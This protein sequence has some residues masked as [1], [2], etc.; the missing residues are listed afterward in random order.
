MKYT[1]KLIFSSLFKNDAALEGRKQKWWIALILFLLSIVLA[2]VP[3]TVSILKTQGD[4]FM[5]GAVYSLDHG[6]VRFT[7][8]LEDLNIDLR[9]ALNEEEKVIVNEGSLWQTSF[10]SIK[11]FPYLENEVTT[12]YDFHYFSYTD[13]SSQELLRIYYYQDYSQNV[14]TAFLTSLSNLENSSDTVNPEL[15][16]FIFINRL[17]F[18]VNLYS[19]AGVNDGTLQG[20]TPTKKFWGDYRNVTLDTN[21]KTFGLSDASGHVYPSPTT[22]EQLFDYQTRVWK[23]Y[24]NFFID[25]YKAN[26]Q[27]NLTTNVLIYLALNTTLSFFMMLLIFLLTRGKNNPNRYITFLESLKI[28]AWMLLSPALLALIVGLI[29]PNFISMAFTLFVGFRTMWLS[30]RQLRPAPP[31]DS[32]PK[33]SPNKLPSRK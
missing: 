27:Y 8:R 4:D 13:N 21:L 10:S 17:N 12:D 22:P 11:T 16:S 30:S 1:F 23:N 7:E 6:L 31:V 2:T 5:N 18:L 25:S 32:G 9:V 29:F 26:K 33:T 14:I 20:N 15:T 28:G 3:V 19:P 24:Q